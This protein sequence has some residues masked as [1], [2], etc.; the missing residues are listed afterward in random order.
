MEIKSE[1]PVKASAAKAWHVLGAEFANIGDWA[2]SL[3]SSSMDEEPVEGSVRVCEGVG[4]GPFP[5]GQVSE[6]LNRFDPESLTF[7]YDGESGMPPFIVKASNT[8]TIEPKGDKN[9]IVKSCALVQFRWWVWPLSWMFPLLIKQD[10][11][12]F[13]EELKYRIEQGA[14]HPRKLAALQNGSK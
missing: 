12:H 3:T 8:W 2:S 6:R 4:F 9:C 10:F 11:K 14:P 1:T 13:T 7:G 5:A